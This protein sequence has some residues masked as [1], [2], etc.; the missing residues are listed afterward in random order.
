MA[1]WLLPEGISDVLPHEARRLEHMRRTLLD[2]YHVHGYELVMPPLLEYIDSLLTAVGTDLDLKTIKLTDQ[3]SGRTLGLRADITPQVAR[4]DAH[5]LNRPGVTRLCY[6]GTVIHARPAHPLAVREPLQIGAELYGC[7]GIAA[8]LEIQKLAVA[9]LRAVGIA[10]IRVDFGHIGIVRSLLAQ[11]PEALKS[12][13][14]AALAVKDVSAMALLSTG[15]SAQTHA[16]L[17]ALVRMHGGHEVLDRARVQFKGVSD[18]EIA[19]DTLEVLAQNC[20]AD[21][22]SFDLA[23]LHGYR[24]YTG[25]NFSAYV[26]GVASALLR[27]GRYDNIGKVFGR[28][29]PATGFS[30]DLRE[31]ALVNSHQTAVVG[32]IQEEVIIAPA[33]LDAHLDALVDQLRADGK[34]VVRQLDEHDSRRMGTHQIKRVGAAWCVTP[35]ASD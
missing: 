29:R 13:V 35:S 14:T 9:S 11:V 12:A 6:A 3:L 24:Y 23:E 27:G 21:A 1:R 2:V 19:L 15:I 5:I 16:H 20:G 33:I 7:E 10:D 18:I 22:I 17:M 25:V 31:V 4:I 34:V 32:G 28:Q 8:D 26:P 30:I